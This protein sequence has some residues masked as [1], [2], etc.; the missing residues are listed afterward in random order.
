[1]S[2]KRKN[3]NQPSSE[4]RVL[5]DYHQEGKRF[6]PPLLHRLSLTGS[7]WITDRVPEL[8]W[9]A[10]LMRNLGVREGTAVAVSVA[11]AAGMCHRTTRKAFAAASDYVELS[12]EDKNCIRSALNAEGVLDKACRGLESLVHHYAEFPLAFLAEPRKA[13]KDVSGANLDDLRATIEE[14]TDRHSHAGT[15]A[16][17][18]VVYIYFVNELLKVTSDSALANFTAI[19]D[20]PESAESRR[21]AASVRATVTLLLTH[22]IPAAWQNYFWNQGRILGRCEVA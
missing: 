22:D 8:V 13:N 5:L 14:S 10:L 21:V 4:R 3:S 15:F 17:A 18:T 6:I 16:Q 7:R 12:D 20:Y 19:E 9:I 2:Q 11:R 1:M